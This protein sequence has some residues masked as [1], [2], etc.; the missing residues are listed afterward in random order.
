MKS[1][2]DHIAPVVQKELWLNKYRP[3]HFID[4][5]SDERTNR[6]VLTWLKSWDACVFRNKVKTVIPKSS[7]F[8]ME[9]KHKNATGADTQEKNAD[10]RPERK[11]SLYITVTSL[12]S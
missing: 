3:K 6:E 11:V 9:D 2:I 5:L 10:V 1:T 8:A 4:L 12:W 7:F